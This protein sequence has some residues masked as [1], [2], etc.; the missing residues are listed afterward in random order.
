MQDE[1]KLLSELLSGKS[2]NLE[3]FIKAKADAMRKAPPAPADVRD[4]GIAIE[5]ARLKQ[6]RA[7]IEQAYR[8]QPNR[9]A[10]SAAA[11]EELGPNFDLVGEPT[12]PE[13][14]AEVNRSSV[15]AIEAPAASKTSAQA[16]GRTQLPS[17]GGGDLVPKSISA[18]EWGGSSIPEINP[19][20]L[21]ATAQG[22]IG[23]AAAMLIHRAMSKK[24]DEPFF[25]AQSNDPFGL[26]D[27]LRI[28]DK[29]VEEQ[30]N[31]E[32]ILNAAAPKQET[33]TP[34]D[35]IETPATAP[36]PQS[37]ISSKGASIPQT[38]PA[39]QALAQI[40]QS[41]EDTALL[42][43]Q[44]LRNNLQ[45][46]NEIT[47]LFS[48]LVSSQAKTKENTG[49]YDSAIKNAGQG[50]EDLK[51]QREQQEVLA[52]L[53]TDKAK[54]D[55]NS[56]VSRMARDS[57]REITQGMNINIPEGMS[58]KQIETLYPYISQ[59]AT[60]RAAKEERAIRLA[61]ASSDKE[62][63]KSLVDQM[64]D[65]KRLDKVNKNMLSGTASSRGSFGSAAKN[66]QSIRNA[67][68]LLTGEKS[69]NDLDSRQMV[70]LA[71]VLDRVLSGG[72]PTISGTEHLTPET[73]QGYVAKFM[74][75]L[76]NKPEGMQQAEFVKRIAKTF[77]KEKKRAIQDIQN[78]QG[79]VLSGVNDIA[80]RL[81][82]D[83]A[84]IQLMNQLEGFGLK[85][86][87]NEKGIFVPE[88]AA[89]ESG[90]KSLS[91]QTLQEYATKHN[92]KIEDAKNLLTKSGYVIK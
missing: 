1:N 20:T 73:A 25:T 82:T 76:S 39:K 37:Q 28:G 65:T 62:A 60:A 68:A 61:Q 88:A 58:A 78:H 2:G 79:E 47:K 13:P 87:F 36:V 77:E 90:S 83:P 63:K 11:F 75:K 66:L 42:E 57:L 48:Q 69:F 40:P 17:V 31:K 50:I 23:A 72:A 91:Q 33:P 16:F 38:E 15:P 35:S 19:N 34:E 3:A 6:Q 26:N 54:A 44:K 27:M 18:S 8:N 64:N 14:I 41:T 52:K 5:E 51:T 45:G 86:S 80:R 32:A 46:S 49:I 24:K 74:E 7:E 56:D 89:K 67:E 85:G 59:A 43:A 70:E 22:P 71:R 53:Q 12:S 84:K 81:D 10:E 9:A 29:P 55:P 30:A 21:K 92:M 4:P